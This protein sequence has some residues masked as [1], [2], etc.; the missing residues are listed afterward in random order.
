MR[1]EPAVVF[2]T[3]VCG[4]GSGGMQGDFMLQSQK[5]GVSNCS[6]MS[7][8]SQRGRNSSTSVGV[9][10]DLTGASSDRPLGAA[11]SW[12]SGA[13]RNISVFSNGSENIPTAAPGKHRQ[14]PAPTGQRRE[15]A[16][17]HAFILLVVII[18]RKDKG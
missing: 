8:F 9:A 12:H 6:V 16:V 15:A 18:G 14:A 2:R 3:G 13:V 5:R 1:P 17:A 10:G 7:G 4:P 11:E